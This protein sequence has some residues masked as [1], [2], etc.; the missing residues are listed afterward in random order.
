MMYTDLFSSLD[1]ARSSFLWLFPL[2]SLFPLLVG[3]IWESTNLSILKSKTSQ[4]WHSKDNSRYN[5]MPSLTVVLF[6]FLLMNNYL[7][8]SPLTYTFTSNLFMVSGLALLL[9]L[10]LLMSGYVKSPVASLAH[11]AP[12]GAPLGLLPFLVLVETISIL[13][14]PLTLTVRLIAN[15][16]AGHIVLG[17]LANVNTSL[18]HSTWFPFVL[19]LSVGY[20][21]FEFFVAIIQAYIFTLLITL[22]STEHP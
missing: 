7:G 9:W 4:V 11:L 20:T 21:L 10:T 16:S 6:L 13:I 8:L 2:L 1:G 22:Y 14:R 18:M 12:S 3:N 15:I 17:L 19:L 5:M